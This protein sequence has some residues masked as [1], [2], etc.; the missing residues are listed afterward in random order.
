MRH[1]TIVLALL[2]VIPLTADAKPKGKGKGKGKDKAKV[3]AK[4]HMD[5]AAKAHKAGQFD[6]ALSSCRLRTT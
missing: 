6:V 2:A 4:V 3:T 5:R 1:A